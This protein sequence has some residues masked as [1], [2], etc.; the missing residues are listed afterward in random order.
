M[1]RLW[2]DIRV[3]VRGLLK[4]R[5]FTL[6]T[7][8]T[9]A[10]C[11]AANVA[12][13][14]VVD[15]VLLKPLP[16]DQPDRLVTITNAYPGAGVAVADNGVPD[17]YD[18]LQGVSA[19]ESL[20]S[21]RSS[22]FT[23]GGDSGQAERIQGLLVTPSFFQV[24]RV[25]PHVG[26]LFTEEE[27]EPGQDQ[28][29]I[30]SY[31]YWQTAFGGQP[32][33]VGQSLRVNG[34]S[35]PIVGV[36]PPGFRFV[37]PEIQMVRA[38]AFTAEERGDDRRHSNN[39]LQLGR[40]KDG[41]SVEQVQSQLNA[42]NAANSE[43]FPQWREILANARFAT[44]A[45]SFQE[46]LVR[47]IR[48]TL[49]LLWG[50]VL[51]VLAI[52]C[53]NVANLVLVRSTTRRREMATRHALGAGFARLGRQSLTESLIVASTGG[54]A[55]LLLG[56]WALAAAPVLGV[57]QLPSG[58]GIAIDPRVV[59]FTFAL[60][61]AV[62]AVMAALPIV[63]L[64]RTDVAQVVREEGRS[65]T[66]TR[67][68]RL[69]RRALVASQVAFALMLLIG[70]GV[71]VAS[72]QRVLAVDPGFRA[73]G[74]VTGL[75]NLPRA[76]FAADSE[77]A[78][79]AII[80][81][82][83][84]RIVER[85]RAVPGVAGA[86]LSSTIPFSG[87]SSDSVIIAEGYQMA[88]GESLISPSQVS[89]TE[90]YFETMGARLIAGRFFNEGD[91]ENRQRVIIIDDRLARKFWPDGD[92]LG[93]RMYQPDNPDAIMEKPSEDKLLTIVG[94]IAE[95]R[96]NNM[97]D[98]VNQR[99]GA[100]YFP[101]RQRPSASMGLAVRG[102]GNS[103]AIGEQARRAV[104]EVEP[105]LPLYNVRTM[106]ERTSEV[107]LDRRTPTL[108]AGGFAVVALFLAAIGI[109]GVLAY[110]VSQRRR[111]IGIRI[112]LG[113][114]APRIF[115]LVLGEGAL[116]VGAGAALGLV[117]AF[118]LRRT[119]ESL[120]YGVGAMD[121]LVVGSVAAVLAA[122][123]CVACIIPARRAAKTD[124]TIALTE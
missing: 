35:M 112:A 23:V 115:R 70:A 14:A 44:N 4:D 31:G 27:A 30:L 117:G 122:V 39:W 43:R 21:Y 29:V 20:S 81:T 121:G 58:S 71:M 103:R 83:L 15:A 78:E 12:I 111:E 42:I 40:L 73:E 37:D 101:F 113:A 10:L 98:G 124:P 52:G 34:V 18:R 45:A 46:F 25:Q 1:D 95:M 76:R 67:R 55:G 32:S 2:Q 88:P 116:I 74:V 3:A 56:W 5:A 123:A 17:Y 51:V 114:G 86:G 80:R 87:S 106:E 49:T 102:A 54:A 7:V 47:D 61:G 92:V 66:A 69:L 107:L 62:G 77:D 100:Y 108:L 48:R 33:A 94:V 8:A 9:L 64:R 93:K 89:V 16:F 72:L 90:G 84:N 60:V 99:P 110:Q 120:L 63:A 28:K 11:L 22:G 26:R 75:L 41:A 24:L 59:V 79:L 119:L 109:Y 105:E 38:V 118:L 50:G 19:L 13:F 65:G 85:V 96:L 68:S 91:T 6:T 36:L 53:V 82:T 104:A 57:D 97:V